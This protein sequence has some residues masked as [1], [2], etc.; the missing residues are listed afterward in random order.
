MR[1]K[2][3]VT[4]AS[5]FIGNSLVNQLLI[6]GHE[7]IPIGKKLKP[8]SSSY[9]QKTLVKV[10]LTKQPLP[11]FGRIDCACLLASKQPFIDDNW[12]QYYKINSEQILKTFLG[13]LTCI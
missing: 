8:W 12:N 5:G 10:D 4:G 7:V 6:S 9:I 11:D 1:M 13:S 3:L 2:I